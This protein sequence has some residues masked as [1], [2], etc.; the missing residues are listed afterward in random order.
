M[1]RNSSCEYLLKRWNPKDASLEPPFLSMSW[2]RTTA[3]LGKD[4]HA[5]KELYLLEGGSHKYG[6]ATMVLRGRRF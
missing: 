1:I 2:R 5:M 6:V 4:L 3:A